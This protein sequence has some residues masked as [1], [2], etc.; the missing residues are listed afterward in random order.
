[1]STNR[2][3]DDII[4]EFEE[5]TYEE[6][7]SLASGAL[8]LVAKAF[9]NLANT[10]RPGELILPFIFTTLGVD[11]ELSEIEAKF[12]NDLFNADFD[13]DALK[14]YALAYNDEEIVELIDK[15]IDICDDETKAAM[16]IFCTCF[17][18]VDNNVTCK[19]T[20]YLV[21]LYS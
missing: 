3:F 8:S 9:S 15:L 19:E 21:K 17:A 16:L 20:E 11:G 6:L 2:T 1:M 18:A 14:N 10:E 7:L 5:K 13:Y 12:L 4:K